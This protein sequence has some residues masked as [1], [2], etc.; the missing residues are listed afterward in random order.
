MEIKGNKEKIE[1]LH[2]AVRHYRLDIMDFLENGALA[3]TEPD[4]KKE[5]ASY[6]NLRNKAGWLDNLENEIAGILLNQ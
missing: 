1:L 5:A 2:E 4:F 3:E 6:R